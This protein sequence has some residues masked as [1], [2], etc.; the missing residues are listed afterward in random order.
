[1]MR[2]VIITTACLFAATTALAEN[3]YAALLDEAVAGIEWDFKKNWAYTETR[4]SGDELWV[5]RYDPSMEK[6]NGWTLLSV[7][8]RKPTAA[9]TQE[10]LGD[11]G[12]DDRSDAGDNRVLRIVEQDSLELLEET[13]DYWLFSFVPSDDEDFM[14]EIEARLRIAKD[15][16]YVESVTLRNVADISPGF[17][18]RL[19]NF[20][21][22]FEFGPAAERGPIVP[23]AV[24][25][26][27][28]GR[29]LLF[30]PIDEAEVVEYSDFEYASEIEAL[31]DEVLA[32]MLERI[33]AMAT[34]YS[35][36]GARHDRLFDNSLEAL[37]KWQAR[38][39]AWLARLYSIEAPAEIGSRD[40]VSYG[41]LL[42]VLEAS[43]G[44]RVCRNELWQA[45]TATSWH[46]QLPF[47]FEIQ[48]VDTPELREQTLARL[49]AV[50][51][52]IDVEIAN[53]RLGLEQGY[54]A[55]RV[56][57]ADVP[58][59]IR[60]LVTDDSIFLN[61]AVRAD[62][63]AFSEKVAAV[64]EQ[65]IVPALH[66]YADFIE[67]DYLPGARE[68]IALSANPDGEACYPALVR[69]F[70]TIQPTAEEIHELGLSQIAR[71]R[72]EMRTTI[73]AHFGGGS[74]EAFLRRVNKDPA[75]TFESETAVLQHS[76][77]ALDAAKAAMPRAFGRLPRA[78]VLIKPY[79][80][81][82]QSGGGEYHSSSEDGTRPGIF[83]IAVTK[84]KERSRAEPLST[85]Y[86]ETYPGHHLQ[87]AISL[88]LGD[89][90]HPLARY[91]WNSGFGEG[92]ALYSERLADEL[93]LFTRPL[94][95]MG[96]YSNQGARAARLVIDT[97]L[98]TKGWTR[99][100]A[101]DYMLANTTWTEIDIQNEINRYISWPGQATA[102]MLGMLEIRRLRHL[103]EQELGDKFE[104]RAFHD[105]VVGYGM[106]TLPMLEASIL[107]WIEENR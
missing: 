95:R 6:D 96:L 22:Q 64:Y 14:R 57:V 48:P 35:I 70:T 91:L 75:F 7:D 10:Y 78:D 54:S 39:D 23:T 63:P 71:I 15:G 46:V 11:K 37:A 19:T 17:G 47:L 92:W 88:E 58:E 18:T 5:G 45:S 52:Y 74:I 69:A 2:R 65:E 102:Y 87:R 55:P 85:L 105:R 60:A 76:L 103:A 66:R 73:D 72:G 80:A 84:P 32:G 107:A 24:K 86:H 27:V 83:Y 101:V 8:G 31:A 9:E 98:H 40:W 50:D 12:D 77:D 21:T 25:V 29:A 93:G 43:V 33:P 44:R 90:V 51:T 81:F 106:I 53:L 20:L 49:G 42:D 26:Q 28:R 13:D 61:P 30:I 34:Q 3:D 4:L 89:R 16:P 94:D 41:I 62:D 100:R 99:Q 82:A 79:P 1:M 104:L 68:G 59:Q 97:G 36:A 56:T 38:E 67:E